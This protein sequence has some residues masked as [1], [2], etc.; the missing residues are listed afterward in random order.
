MVPGSDG[1]GR[2]GEGQ[3]GLWRNRGKSELSL[4]LAAGPTAPAPLPLL[5]ADTEVLGDPFA[6]LLTAH[7]AAPVEL[8]VAAGHHLGSPLLHRQPTVP[9]QSPTAPL[10]PLAECFAPLQALSALCA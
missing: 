6:A 9:T 7:G 8:A 3:I 5:L 2:R 10:L 1:E 4:E